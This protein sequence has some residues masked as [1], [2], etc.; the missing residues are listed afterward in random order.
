MDRL[1][2][3]GGGH[4]APKRVGK[5]AAVTKGVGSGNPRGLVPETQAIWDEKAEFWDERMGEGNA[6]QRVLIGPASERLLA[7][8]P[9]ELIV[10]VAC[11][12]GVFARRLAELG[13]RVVATDFSAR[14]LE[15]ARARTTEHADRIEYRLVDATDDVE[16]LTLWEG[17]FDAAVCNQALMDM[18]V[19]E[20]L[21]RALA[22]LL[23]PA[24]RF[25]FAVPHPAFNSLGCRWG[26]ESEVRDER[27][28]E[29]RHVKVVDYLHVPPGKGPGMPDEPAPH[30]Y[31]HRPLSALLGAC[32]AA[33]FVLDGLEEPAFGPGDV[34]NAA[35]LSWLTY[36]DIPPVL[37]ARARRRG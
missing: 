35:A 7:I 27:L 8:R 37:V 15:L 6:F 33:G 13:A 19:I 14:F 23:T 22:R 4:G 20:P 31:F 30:W 36:H 28:V 25:V 16:L 10:D 5:G 9:D 1:D 18:P 24:G 26:F 34:G 21:L 12:N 2:V 3:G 17:Q 29:T 11:G 32:F